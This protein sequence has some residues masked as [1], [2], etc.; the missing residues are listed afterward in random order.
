MNIHQIEADAA[1][2]SLQSSARGLTG[3][4]AARRLLHFGENRIERVARVPIGLRLLR[5]FTHFFA[6]ILWLAALLAM[7]ADLNEPGQG[8]R[9]LAVA[10][11]AV[12]LVNG[13]F[14]FWQE[15]RAE[16]AFLALQQL[17]PRAVTTIRNGVA[18]RVPAETLV[19]GDIIFVEAGDNV[20][21]DCRLIEAF[22]LRVNNATITGEAR[23][24]ARDARPSAETDPLRSQNALLAGTTVVAGSG[25]AV[26]VATG[27]R[28]EFGRITHLTQS[29]NETPS[30]LQ[31]ELS[32]LSRVIAALAIAAGVLVFVIGEAIG[33]SRAANFVFA[34]GVIVANVPEGL[35]PTLTLALAMA[36]RRMARQH[37][38][39][40]RLSSVET[41]GAASVIC[42]DK[43]GTL[44]EN[45]MVARE[46]FSLG[47]YN[48][49]ADLGG[50]E[51]WIRP[52]IEGARWC[53]D[54]KDTGRPE[55]RWIG[56]PMEVA[57]VEMATPFVPDEAPKIDEIPFDSDRKRLVT[58][59]RTREGLALYAKGALEE[60]L[61]RCRH[62][63]SPAGPEPL[64]SEHRETFIAAQSRMAQSG[65]RVLGFAHRSLPDPYDPERL[66]EDLVLDA[67][68]G[69]EDPPRPEVPAAIAQ[70]R[71]A[72]IRVVMVTGDH[73]QTAVA[74]GREIGL[75]STDT[76]RVITG[77]WMHKMSDAEMWA[78]V[79]V[80]DIVFAR[81]GA[82]QKL[83]IVTALQRHHLTVAATGD[84]VN[85]APALRAANVGIA[86]GIT[87]TDVARQASDMVLL[88]DNFASIV[89]AIEEGRAVYD[90]IR[91]FL[92]YILSS[93]VPE[94]V[95]YLAFA[96]FNVPLALT[97]LQIL[98]VDLGT[99]I[100]PALGLGAERPEP[101]VMDRPPRSP[102]E[103]VLTSSLLARAYLF[104][105]GLEA[106]AAMA[107]FFY[108]FPVAGYVA[109]TTAC[110]GA[111]V[112]M[113]IVN[114]HLCRSDKASVF[115]S[116]R[117]WNALIVSGMVTE[118]VLMILIAYTPIGN[119]LF[120]TAPI[121]PHAW[122][123]VLPFAATML[124]A[125]EG[126]KAIVRSRGFARRQ[127]AQ[128]PAM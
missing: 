50:P 66:E 74:I 55:A 21:A 112:V 89:S 79:D 115:V 58:V 59:H 108:V 9:A 83:R 119:A 72:G 54:L 85:D 82:D 48:S 120:G 27:M 114:V 80:P 94:L 5:E 101:G 30:A 56:D 125:E 86:M 32:A 18:V 62:V 2:V 81:V 102:N 44:T 38:L 60:L 7:I 113:Q 91:K 4:E 40:R 52:L 124:I 90:N 99:D 36:S 34:I 43:T 17:L 6:A 78:A 76:P 109:A 46:V 53:H 103:R 118:T 24:V 37:V 100:V 13:V 68:V 8:M 3:A 10:I 29:T 97:I 126:R 105:G 61:P 107:A 98:A 87:G 47:G 123:F 41:L 12:I 20:S 122:L 95:P 70:C 23:P 45:R 116:A 117:R 31:R 49:P 64:T 92:T 128:Q 71:R 25:R 65:L 127:R 84:G 93:N 88:D 28:T 51:A 121:S 77:D 96:F 16:T 57:L 1:L 73:P 33:L 110:L 14:S 69:L 22:A 19:P 111:I 11:V 75:F 15:Y 26:V 35:L 106:V 63:T 67:L 39:V 104:L 42:S